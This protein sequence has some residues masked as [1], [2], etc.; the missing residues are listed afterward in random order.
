[1]CY[2]RNYDFEKTEIDIFMTDHDH[3]LNVQMN[4]LVGVQQIWSD[5]YLGD[6]LPCVSKGSGTLKMSM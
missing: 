5:T 3:D 4:L 2:A 1:M 6:V